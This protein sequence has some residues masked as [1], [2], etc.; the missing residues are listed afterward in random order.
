MTV[1]TRMTTKPG[2]E[3]NFTKPKVSRSFPGRH[4]EVVSFRRFMMVQAIRYFSNAGGASANS[5]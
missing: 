2:K 3:K 5:C 4:Q 1:N